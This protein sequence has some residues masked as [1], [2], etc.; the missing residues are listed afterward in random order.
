MKTHEQLA[1][2]PRKNNFALPV[3]RSGDDKPRGLRNGTHEVTIASVQHVELQTKHGPTDQLNITFSQGDA[4][5]SQ[6]YFLTTR[7]E[8][9]TLV[10]SR[11]YANLILALFPGEAA[12]EPATA[13]L[14]GILDD[15]RKGVH[16]EGTSLQIT[17]G[18]KNKGL[19]IRQ[20]TEGEGYVI[21]SK[22]GLNPKTQEVKE[23]RLFPTRVFETVK[24]ANQAIE[25]MG[26]KVAFRAITKHAPTEESGSASVNEAIL[27]KIV[28]EQFA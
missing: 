20:A 5:M 24:D 22:D 28:A 2:Q 10:L 15:P 21:V 16:L 8:N 11:E 14:N 7:K 23:K 17:I 26:E 1:G 4:R 9:G 12:R 25:D 18:E 27:K 13:V 3:E 19:Y 6:R